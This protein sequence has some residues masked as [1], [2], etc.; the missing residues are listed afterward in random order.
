MKKYKL[1]LNSLKKAQ[2][3]YCRATNK[4]IKCP[5]FRRVTR[6]SFPFELH[7]ACAEYAMQHPDK[8]IEL[9]G[10]EVVEE[11]AEGINTRGK[12]VNPRLAEILGVNAGEKFQIPINGSIATFEITGDGHFE[13]TPPNMVGSTYLLLEAIERPEIIIR[14]SRITPEELAICK[15]VGAKWLCMD[16]AGFK[17]DLWNTKPSKTD[18]GIY[19]AFGV[20]PMARLQPYVFPSLKPGDCINVEEMM[21]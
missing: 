3:A 20:D 6:K 5:F 19:V 15:A 17:A 12:A 13:T 18:K 2:E 7:E 4:C 14:Q 8:A 10:L 21:K 11:V 9:M 1:T 16:D